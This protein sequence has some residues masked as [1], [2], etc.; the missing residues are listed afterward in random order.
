MAKTIIEK[1]IGN[2]C[3]REVQPGDIADVEIDLRAA[4]DFGGANV[5]K[6][7]RDSRLGIADPSKTVFTFDCNPGGSDQS[8]ASNQH[9]CRLF[10][11]ETGVPVYDIDQ[12]IGT[13]LA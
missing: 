2:H 11:R 9:I 10:A 3:G 6:N 13:H 7:L 5:V 12:G 1:I 8:Y 4:R